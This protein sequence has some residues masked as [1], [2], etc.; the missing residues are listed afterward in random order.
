MAPFDGFVPRQEDAR[1]TAKRVKRFVDCSPANERRLQKHAI[2]LAELLLDYADRGERYPLAPQMRALLDHWLNS[3][4]SAAR[5]SGSVLGYRLAMA[6]NYLAAG[7]KVESTEVRAVLK[8]LGLEDRL[9]AVRTTLNSTRGKRG[10]KARGTT[11]AWR[12]YSTL[13][14]ETDAIPRADENRRAGQAEFMAHVASIFDPS[15]PFGRPKKPD[16]K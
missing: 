6:A 3:D 15:S 4:R 9:K 7:G 5:V 8:K 11:V 1:V 14:V 2:G 10:P 13:A 16:P 12:I